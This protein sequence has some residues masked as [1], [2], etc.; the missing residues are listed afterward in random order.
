V[1]SDGARGVL[2]SEL[3]AVLPFVPSKAVDGEHLSQLIALG[4]SADPRSTP[5]QEIR[6]VAPCEAIN[7][8]AR[9]A[10][11]HQEM[12]RVGVAFFRDAHPDL[13]L[14][15]F[16]QVQ[17]AV[18]RA[19]G[20]TTHV[21]VL[22]GGGLDSS[23]ILA[24]ALQLSAA[25]AGSTVVALAQTWDGPGDDRPYLAEL[26]RSLGITARRMAAEDAAPQFSRSLCADAQ[27][28]MSPF[29]CGEMQL[30]TECLDAQAILAGHG[31][32]LVF[33]GDVSFAPQLLAGHPLRALHNAMRLQVSWR[34]SW[35][36]RLLWAARPLVAPL[37]PRAF[38][39]ARR[40]RSARRPWMTQRLVDS[41]EA[42]LRATVD[43][44]PPRSPAEKMA[45][46]CSLPAFQA[47]TVSWGQLAS[48]TGAAPVDVYRDAELLRFLAHVD[49]ATLQHGHRYRGLYREAM[50]GRIPEPVRLRAD[51]AAPVPLVAATAAAP[52]ARAALRGLATGDELAARGLVDR[53]VF[54]ETAAAWSA[55]LNGQASGRAAEDWDW[56]RWCQ[57]WAALATECFLRTVPSG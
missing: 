51:K 15:L 30:W 28:Q 7:V 54:R 24:L 42:P 29:A 19:M 20:R 55:T 13:A 18:E 47:L 44:R 52:E 25:R 5:Y 50:R 27:P 3:E 21:A 2:S 26:E 4:Y 16:A 1:S 22:A 39:I 46:F 34:A 41:I 6:R 56:P 31:G 48:V 23:G 9:G 10:Q 43:R 17:A 8:D 14:E 45:A 40:R 33:G 11:F 12:P 35:H 38:L 36:E 37:L 57:V 49:P 53:N 32:D